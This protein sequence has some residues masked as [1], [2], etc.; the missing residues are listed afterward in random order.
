MSARH[1]VLTVAY[2]GTAY[3]GFQRQR[4]GP[5]A[6]IQEVLEGAI[7]QA[8][9]APVRLV[10]AGR[11]DAGVHAEKQV[12]SFRAA[13][14]I[15]LPRLPYAV[16]R[17]LPPD[18]VVTGALEAGDR[19]HPR[20]SAASKVYRY[21]IWRAEF[22][23]PFLRRY[24]WHRPE[25]LDV[26]AMR[27]AASLLVGR[28]DFAALG[29]AGRPVRDT[30]RTVFRCEVEERPPLLVVRVE[31]DGFLYKMARTIVGTLVEV[32]RGKLAP[33]GL[34]E[35]LASRDRRRAGPAA[36]ALGLCLEDVR[37]RSV[38]TPAGLL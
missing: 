23:S 25:P 32:G 22:P 26:E 27:R 20:F 21:T 18:I 2:D 36:P 11:T 38:D 14:T 34:R 17:F 5:K 30:V 3:C 33:E 9:G 12:V 37:Y 8:L 31:A 6:S 10:G 35:I 16:N 28:Q 13:T 29:A 24:S 4:P 15:P 7:R 1:V 19:F